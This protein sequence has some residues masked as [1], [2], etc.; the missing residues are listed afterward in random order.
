MRNFL[1]KQEQEIFND[2]GIL[3]NIINFNHH[4]GDQVGTDIVNIA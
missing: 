3:I 1:M 4:F 2:S